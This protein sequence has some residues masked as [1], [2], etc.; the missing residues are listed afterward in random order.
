MKKK[1]S[2]I[3]QSIF[4]LINLLTAEEL[5]INNSR[6]IND[7]LEELEKLGI[8]Q[9]QSSNELIKIKENFNQTDIEL[10]MN[11]DETC[12]RY[13]QICSSQ[14]ELTEDIQK[15]YL[16]KHPY[17]GMVSSFGNRVQVTPE[18]EYHRADSI[19]DVFK[20][21]C[22]QHVLR[23]VAG[24]CD[25]LT[26]CQKKKN[27]HS[28]TRNLTNNEKIY[29]P[30]CDPVTGLFAEKQCHHGIG[31]CWCA[32][33]DNKKVDNTVTTITDKK[34]NDVPELDCT[35]EIM[36]ISQRVRRSECDKNTSR[37]KNFL[38]QVTKDIIYEYRAIEELKQLTSHKKQ[39]TNRSK[40]VIRQNYNYNLYHNSHSGSR[41]ESYKRAKLNLQQQLQ[42]PYSTANSKFKR[43]GVQLPESLAWKFDQLDTNNDKVLSNKELSPFIQEM[44]QSSMKNK[45]GEED[46]K[47]KDFDVCAYVFKQNCK[48]NTHKN[49][50]VLRIS[51][52]QSC[53]NGK[54]REIIEM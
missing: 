19:C 53:L 47:N 37:W 30:N 33:P 15:P 51:E 52:W 39:L 48:M 6:E 42:H 7:P 13:N 54:Y 38:N 28:L 43:N 17:C 32:Y 10:K 50:N 36:K 4:Y 31:Y 24:D 2:I 8:L 18:A 41:T 35:E 29:I 45:A 40:R 5:S 23:F 26:L 49:N 3:C 25:S 46:S 44:R 14:S 34:N 1:R 9:A 12:S 27:F 20:L 16:N 22:Q 21:R 11:E